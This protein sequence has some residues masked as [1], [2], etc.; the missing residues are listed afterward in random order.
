MK[1]TNLILLCGL[2]VKVPQIIKM[3]GAG[4]AKGVSMLAVILELTALTFTGAYNFAK[5]FPFR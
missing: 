4:S 2:V 5:Q 3:I 1:Q